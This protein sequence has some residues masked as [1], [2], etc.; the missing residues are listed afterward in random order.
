[1][2]RFLPA[3]LLAFASAHAS[4]GEYLIT[5][6]GAKGD[7]AYDNAPVI[8]TLIS[9]F[10]PEGGT[11]LIPAGD[12]RLQSPVIVKS[13]VTIR[14]VNYGQRSNVD[15]T[16][17]GV[18]FPAGGS[19]L[20]LGAGVAD[21]ILAPAGG[22]ALTGLAIRDLAISGSDGAVYQTGIHLE[23]AND[24]TRLSGV[25]CVNLK[26]GVRLRE[27][28]R[29]TVERCWLG[30]CQA[31]L[32][33]ETGSECLVADNSLGG[34]PGGVTCEFIGQQR[35]VFTG[36]NVFPDG[37]TGLR[38]ANS[39]ACLVSHNTFTGWYT[40][41]VQIEGNMNLFAHNTLTAVP[42]GGAW[43]ADPLGRD[44]FH[45]FVRIS[46]NDNV[47]ESSTLFSWQ[48]ENDCRIHCAAGER[49]TFRNL[50]IGALGS[51]R[52]IFTNG[53]LTSWTRITRSGIQAEIDLGGSPTARVTYDP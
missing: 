12:F 29:A 3:L 53:D 37:H 51:S 33:I 27:A 46:G 41:M 26:K 8:N 24:F 48:P 34:Q 32:Q 43:P 50:D 4:E 35:L 49:N 20:I 52:K 16:P 6:H 47:M 7:N 13:N 40:G 5:D 15:P 30:E 14:G 19:K 45:G 23:R 11:I 38:F 25:N 22:P 39:H 17:P 36:N 2:T 44:G 28:S 10:G 9:S 1:V 18:F 42:R 31:P 21:G